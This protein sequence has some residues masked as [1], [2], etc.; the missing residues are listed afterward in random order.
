MQPP[1]CASRA[2]SLGPLRVSGKRAGPPARLC[3]QHPCLR[4]A[5]PPRGP[6]WRGITSAYKRRP[7]GGA[8]SRR[9][10]LERCRVYPT[11]LNSAAQHLQLLSG[12]STSQ[13][14]PPTPGPQTGV[15]LLLSPSPLWSSLAG[16]SGAL[17]GK[18]STKEVY[19][20]DGRTHPG[21]RRR[22]L[23]LKVEPS[24]GN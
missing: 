23:T 16:T 6:H 14:K 4:S 11:S 5:P 17:D 1:A 3:R 22:T 13:V 9:R 2:S 12:V 15:P 21:V 18:R 10:I 24:F 19:R 8:R 20:C 7:L